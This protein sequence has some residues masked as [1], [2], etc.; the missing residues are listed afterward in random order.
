LEGG[1][2]GVEVE[3]G[4]VV[5]LEDGD[6]QAASAPKRSTQAAADRDRFDVFRWALRMHR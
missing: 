5:V 3:V 2:G 6:E 1:G 4:A